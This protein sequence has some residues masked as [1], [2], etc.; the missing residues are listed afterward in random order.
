[1]EK[2]SCHFINQSE[3]RTKPNRDLLARV[4]PRLLASLR[5]R[6]LFALSSDWFNGLST[7]VVI[8]QSDYFENFE[9][10]SNLK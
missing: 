2:I 7:P 3:V 4:F 10:C 5:R 8:S 1:M 9:N 6:H